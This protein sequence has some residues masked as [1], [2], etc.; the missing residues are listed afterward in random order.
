MQ[1]KDSNLRTVFAN[2]WRMF[3][4]TRNSTDFSGA[5]SANLPW[6]WA[7]RRLP[8]AGEISDKSDSKN[9][10]FRGI[11][12]A[13]AGTRWYHAHESRKK[14]AVGWSV[15]RWKKLA[16][17]IQIGSIADSGNELVRPTTERRADR[18]VRSPLIIH[19][20][21][22]QRILQPLREKREDR[23]LSGYRRHSRCVTSN[24]PTRVQHPDV[25][26]ILRH[27]DL[28]KDYAD[29]YDRVNKT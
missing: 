9:R 7:F 27:Y 6:T 22:M 18:R 26:V 17:T 11:I 4:S 12:F 24:V 29:I 3:A 28:P 14:R 21:R 2:R 1:K 20:A 10:S 15:S 13:D 16:K 8:V 5:C 23:I 25:I 19:V